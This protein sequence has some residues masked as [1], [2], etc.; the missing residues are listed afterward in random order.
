MSACLLRWGGRPP[1]LAFC[2]P[3]QHGVIPTPASQHLLSR[4]CLPAAHWI[5]VDAAIRREYVLPVRCDQQKPFR[6]LAVLVLAAC[7]LLL[8][9]CASTRPVGDVPPAPYTRIARP[10]ANTVQLQIAV[11]KFVPS[12]HRGPVV[13]LAG[14]SHIGDPDY[15]HA[16]Q[17][18]LDAQTL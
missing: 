18:Q 13:W 9:S 6:Q 14:T 16:L 17:K 15:Y 5:V 4:A 10:D 1:S 8:A 11:R 7:G 2:A 3:C 12:H